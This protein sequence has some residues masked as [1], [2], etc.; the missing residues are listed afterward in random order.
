[1]KE[2]AAAYKFVTVVLV[3][4]HVTPIQPEAHGSVPLGH[5]GFPLKACCIANSA[6][7][8]HHFAEEIRQG[9]HQRKIIM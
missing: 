1:V 2:T 6:M 8:A 7:T 4:S 9:V 3:P 5:G